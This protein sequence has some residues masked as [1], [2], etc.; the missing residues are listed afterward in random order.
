MTNKKF[1]M[2]I[3]LQAH[4]FKNIKEA[5]LWANENVVGSFYNIDTQTNIIVSRSAIRKCLSESAIKKSVSL[6]IHF[7]ALISLRELIESAVLFEI[8][9]DRNLDCN[10]INIQ[11]LYAYAKLEGKEYTIKLTIKTVEYEGNLFYS[12]EVIKIESSVV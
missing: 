3:T 2:I 11:R 6:D 4:K 10:I 8:Q 5:R 9:P 1:P 7:S 12:C